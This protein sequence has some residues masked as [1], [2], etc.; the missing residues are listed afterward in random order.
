MRFIDFSKQN[1]NEVMYID[2]NNYLN[3]L[4]CDD[5][6]ILYTSEGHH[7]FEEIAYSYDDEHIIVVFHAQ[8]QHFLKIIP[9]RHVI[10]NRFMFT[11]VCGFYTSGDI[12][13]FHISPNK[14]RVAIVFTVEN[15]YFD[16]INGD[17]NPGVKDV[18]K[19]F[20]HVYEY[21][22]G[23]TA[24][25]I[26]KKIYPENIKI[27]LS[28]LDTIAITSFVNQ[29]ADRDNIY[30]RIE[31]YDFISNKRIF[32]KTVDYFIKYLHFFPENETHHNNIVLITNNLDSDD[33]NIRLIDLENKFGEKQNLPIDFANIFSID[34]NK[35][36]SIVLR[37]DNGILY[38]KTLSESATHLFP[39][40][41]IL[42]SSF[43]L[44]GNKIAVIMN[45]DQQQNEHGYLTFM[46]IYDF[47]KREVSF[48]SYNMDEVLGNYFD[49]HPRT[50]YI[51]DEDDQQELIIRNPFLDKIYVD[52]IVTDQEK[53]QE[54]GSE[55][56]FNMIEL[57]EE[58][59]GN[60]LSSD[61][62]NLVIFFKN[63]EDDGFQ[64]TCLNFSRLKQY[65][66]NPNH[67]FYSCVDELDF[68]VYKNQSF[69]DEY[70][71]I[72]THAHTLFVNYRDIRQKYEERQNM[73]F[74]ELSEQIKKT[75]SFNASFTLQFI[76]SN[77]CQE[78]SEINVYRIIF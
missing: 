68:R 78:G 63:P 52:N 57:N 9:R 46:S 44:S 43:S 16:T 17:Y 18:K 74:L 37:T 75:I 26:L 49:I 29:T 34:I 21:S 50:E 67:I 15:K 69:L 66:K 7:K 35:N 39:D 14:N 65:L 64:A 58:N 61:P 38:L 54:Y 25:L 51:T 5:Y 24:R 71:K 40:K 11:S 19:K 22:N 3:I 45:S 56:C 47:D 30:S 12:I 28:E 55:N 10:D 73:I 76:S 33:Y 36:G 1:D 8:N 59:I 62:D 20:L 2:Q 60:Y 32:K 41:L 53:L 31:I 70:L 48:D 23:G 77:H 42:H 72:P 13:S 6:T 27:D 4:N